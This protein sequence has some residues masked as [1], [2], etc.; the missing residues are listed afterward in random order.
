MRKFRLAPPTRGPSSPAAQITGTQ[1]PLL[2]G[3]WAGVSPARWAQLGAPGFS[4]NPEGGAAA[5]PGCRMHYSRCLLARGKARRGSQGEG[6]RGE[7]RRAALTPW[8]AGP[9]KL[10]E[11]RQSSSVVKSLGRRM[12]RRAL[13]RPPVLRHVTDNSTMERL[14]LLL[15]Q[16]SCALLGS[17]LGPLFSS[18]VKWPDSPYCRGCVDGTS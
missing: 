6:R 2:G 13:S 4:P 7:A 1:R 18:F 14:V 3:G 15:R 5:A 16:T 12:S 9:E 11:G 8:P 10:R 17:T